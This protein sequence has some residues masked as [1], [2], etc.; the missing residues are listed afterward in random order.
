MLRT[1]SLTPTLSMLLFC[2]LHCFATSWRGAMH[3]PVRSAATCLGVRTPVATLHQRGKDLGMR[4]QAR[5]VDSAKGISVFL[6]GSDP[7]CLFPPDFNSVALNLLHVCVIRHV[8]PHS[9]TLFTILKTLPPSA[10]SDSHRG[11]LLLCSQGL[12]LS[13]HCK[14]ARSRGAAT[15]ITV[16]PPRR[17][18]PARLTLPGALFGFCVPCSAFY[19]CAYLHFS[20]R[21]TLRCAVLHLSRGAAQL[22]GGKWV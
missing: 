5:G 8:G 3:C 2:F 9:R 12:A 21:S 7:S 18:G 16:I 20:P 10:C 13:W 22:A 14:A 11:A 6:P 4:Y 1:A 15:L 19:R 17:H